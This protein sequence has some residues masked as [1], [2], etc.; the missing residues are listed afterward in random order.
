MDETDSVRA[1]I[2]S[3]EAQNDYRSSPAK[4]AFVSGFSGLTQGQ[5]QV[6][7]LRFP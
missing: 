7:K 5:N 1:S 4:S 6:C 2:G 3:S